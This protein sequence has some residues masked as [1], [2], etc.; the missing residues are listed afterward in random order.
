MFH[1]TVNWKVLDDF[2]LF[3][4][5]PA[6]FLINQNSSGA[7]RSLINARDVGLR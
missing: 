2:L 5:L 7:S 6:P 3:G 1:L 4:V